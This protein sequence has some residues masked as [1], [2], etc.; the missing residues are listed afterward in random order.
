MLWRQL[1]SDTYGIC[2]AI[3]FVAV[4]VSY[5]CSY[6]IPF[7]MLPNCPGFGSK[8]IAVSYISVQS[9]LLYNILAKIMSSH[10][11]EKSSKEKKA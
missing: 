6:F 4:R 1:K 2:F 9:F 11:S 5:H 3:L 8:A 7:R 10:T